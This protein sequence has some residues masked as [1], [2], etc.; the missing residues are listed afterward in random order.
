MTSPETKAL[1]LESAV[2][3]VVFPVADVTMVVEAEP[4]PAWTF[5]V[6]PFEV[7]PK[8][9]NVLPQGAPA[10]AIVSVAAVAVVVE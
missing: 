7:H 2:K 8:L 4:S 10:T 3:A 6:P 9:L 5:A 1:L